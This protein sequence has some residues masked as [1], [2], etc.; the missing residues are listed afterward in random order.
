MDVHVF[1]GWPTQEV[2]DLDL[3]SRMLNSSGV[4]VPRPGGPRA[5]VSIHP[6]A[7][8][9]I[10]PNQ[11]L[12]QTHVVAPP[13]FGLVLSLVPPQSGNTFSVS[14][15]GTPGPSEFITIE[16]D[17]YYIAS[18]GGSTV[19]AI[20]QGLATQIN[21]FASLTN[22]LIPA[23]TT[24]VTGNTLTISGAAYCVPRLGAAGTLGKVTH[25]QRQS[26]MIT[27]W[28]PDHKSRNTIA[29]AIDNVIKRNLTVTMPDTSMALI[30]YNRTNLPEVTEI[31]SCYRR[32]LIYSVDYATLELFPGYVIT[33]VTTELSQFNANFVGAVTAE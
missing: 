9:N 17:Q 21:G 23:Y 22:P 11:I 28:A 13:V 26:V 25:K 1:E 10:I 24:S 7:G 12:D 19:A 33:S 18:A 30:T 32:D 6:M 16:L 4:V 8:A 5:N 31:V 27:T 2:L 20:L 14:V 29:A 3:T 15:T